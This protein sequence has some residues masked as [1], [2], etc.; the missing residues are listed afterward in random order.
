MPLQKIVD[1]Y[2]ERLGSQLG[3]CRQLNS[4][5]ESNLRQRWRDVS[6]A[7]G[8]NDPQDILEG[9]GAYYDKIS[10]SNFLMGR[11]TDFKA[12]FDWIHASSNYLKIYEGNYENGRHKD[13]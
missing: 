13:R 3:V 4:K 11:K 7:I 6:L 8:S 10:R 2:N 5:R 1:L 12:T 9:F